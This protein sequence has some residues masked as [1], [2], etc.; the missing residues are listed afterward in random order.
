MN[1]RS[2]NQF[3]RQMFE[4]TAPR[5]V[6]HID[7]AF[8][9]LAEGLVAYA[10]LS[11]GERILDLGT[12]SGLAAWAASSKV[13]LGVGLDYAKPLL[14]EARAK[15]RSQSHNNL[16]WIQGDMHN[17][18]LASKAFDVVLGSFSF[19]STEPSRVFP[20]AWRVLVPGGRLV[21]QEWGQSDL[22]SEIVYDVLVEYSV[23]DPPAP[24]AAMREAMDMPGEWDDLESL[25][26]L[27]N[28]LTQSGFHNV[29]V[30]ETT[31]MVLFLGIDAFLEYK[32]AWDTR[33]QEV[34]AMPEDMRQLMFSEMQDRLEPLCNGDESLSWSPEIIRVRALKP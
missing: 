10:E 30:V 33:H 31:E 20:E 11:P 13:A 6:Q 14:L 26:D 5:Y 27:R 1:T 2:T 29:E 25:E 15:P 22:L 21:M 9:P 17:L 12:G 32:L 18:G 16:L 24:L 23:D 4:R 19:N 7:P 28:A 34:S 8:K 3:V